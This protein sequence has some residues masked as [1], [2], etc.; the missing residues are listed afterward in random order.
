[1]KFTEYEPF[2]RSHMAQIMMYLQNHGILCVTMKTVEEMYC[3][4]CHEKDYSIWQTPDNDILEEF[5][6]WLA[7]IE[8]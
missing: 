8:L 1:M 5:A 4:F 3:D 2:N 6:D 7:K